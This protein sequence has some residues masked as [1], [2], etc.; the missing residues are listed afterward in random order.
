MLS[1]VLSNSVSVR[2]RFQVRPARHVQASRA[3][4]NLGVRKVVSTV[5]R[6]TR[7]HKLKGS[8]K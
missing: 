6:R 3:E 2:A 4:R 8:V 5:V 1:T 7:L